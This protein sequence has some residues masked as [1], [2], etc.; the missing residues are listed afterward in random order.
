MFSYLHVKKNTADSQ[1]LIK[2]LTAHKTSHAGSHLIPEQAWVGG[3][4][5]WSPVCRWDLVSWW[6]VLL[7][8]NPCRGRRVGVQYCVCVRISL[9]PS[10]FCTH[11]CLACCQ[12]SVART[13]LVCTGLGHGSTTRAAALRKRT[14]LKSHAPVRHCLGIPHL[15]WSTRAPVSLSTLQH[16]FPS[17]V[18]PLP[19]PC[20]PR[21][22]YK[23]TSIPMA[24]MYLG[25]KKKQWVCSSVTVIWDY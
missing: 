15:H 21:I 25:L 12:L 3:I 24:G 6:L 19:L 4:S 16:P 14:L 11:V 9:T 17:L 20:L 22:I 23:E 10:T 1:S 13:W 2:G 7:M 18:S 8:T 5:L